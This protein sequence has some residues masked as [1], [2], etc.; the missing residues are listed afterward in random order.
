ME[1]LTLSKCV[2]HIGPEIFEA[3]M[4]YVA[5]SRVKSL[6]GL[7]L[8]AFDSSRIYASDKVKQYYDECIG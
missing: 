5:L 8:T 3:G 7:S 4:L 6:Q 2:V 1:G